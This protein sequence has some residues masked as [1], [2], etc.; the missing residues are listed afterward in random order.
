LRRYAKALLVDAGG[1]DSFPDRGVS[2]VAKF[3]REEQAGLIHSRG[4]Q[5][6]PYRKLGTAVV[7]GSKLDR[8]AG[9]GR[10]GSRYCDRNTSKEC[11]LTLETGV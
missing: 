2:A 6:M 11:H 7:N 5:W 9:W 3:F 8:L 10:H 4:A 1:V